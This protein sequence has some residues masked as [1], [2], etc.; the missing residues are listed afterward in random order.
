[1]QRISDANEAQQQTAKTAIDAMKVRSLDEERK[2]TGLERED[3]DLRGKTTCVVWRWCI[4]P[5][6]SLCGCLMCVHVWRA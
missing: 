1:M 2:L 4:S 6:Q 3:D 5:S